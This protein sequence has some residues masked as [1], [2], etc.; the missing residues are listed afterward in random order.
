M[1]RKD[2]GLGLTTVT[3]RELYVITAGES[4]SAQFLAPPSQ[5]RFE[6]QQLRVNV[7]GRLFM[8]TNRVPQAPLTVSLFNWQA[9]EWQTWEVKPGANS[10]PEGERYLS[11]VGEVRARFSVEQQSAQSTIREA[12]LSRFDVTLLGMVR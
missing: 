9:A 1:N 5:G 6:L 4:V 2:L 7:D 8:R 10:I 12:Q 3:D 11:A